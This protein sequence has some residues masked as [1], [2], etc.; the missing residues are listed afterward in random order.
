LFVKGYMPMMRRFA[1]LASSTFYI[2]FTAGCGSGGS[3]PVSSGSAGFTVSSLTFASTIV[4]T[5]AGAQALIFTNFTAVSI[6]IASVQIS[7]NSANDFSE[8]NTCGITLAAGASCTILV[9]F[10]PTAAGTCIGTVSVV[11]SA[12]NSPQVVTLSGTGAAVAPLA[13]L[14]PHNGLTYGTT[15]IAS[16]ATTQTA[17][18]TNTGTAALTISGIAFIG[19]NPGDF[20][21]TNT[22][23]SSVAVS[24]SCTI[25]V[26][27]TPTAAGARSA[28]LTVTDNSST[29]SQSI[30]VA[31]TGAATAVPVASLSPTSLTFASG[32]AQVVT[33]SNTGASAMTISGITITGANPTNFTETNTCGSSLASSTSCTISVTFSPTGSGSYAATLNV[34]DNAAGSPQAASLAGTATPVALLSPTNLTFTAAISGTTTVAQTVTVT[35]TGTASMTGV[36]VSLTG[37]SAA[38]FAQTNTCSST[39]AVNASCTISVTFT[40][41]ASGT[42]NA[43]ISVTDN[44]SGSPQTVSLSGLDT[45]S[46][47]THTLYVFPQSDNSVTPLYALINNAK[48]TIDMAMYSLEDTIFSGDLVAACNRGVTVRVILD[49]TTAE[50]SG[51]TPAFK[52]LNAV[53]HCSAVWANTAFEN[54]HQKTIIVDGTQASI[55]SLNLQSQYYSTSRDY[56]L[57]ENDT[58]D[59]AAIEATFNAD[60]AA[61]TTSSGTVGAS[62]F[63][64]QPGAGDDLIW[65]PTT[66]EADMLAIINNATATLLVENE[67][68]DVSYIVNALEAA[69]KRGV[70][71]HIAMEDNSNYSSYFAELVAAGCGLHT[72]PYPTNGF[73][74]HA[75]AVVA[76]YGLNTQNIYMGSINYSNASMTK[77]RELGLYISDAT[78]AQILYATMTNDYANGANY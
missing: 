66:A 7:G 56:V 64:Y 19:T 20:S 74:I 33:L 30:V 3:A 62:D 65:S 34:A 17:T 57:V 72:Y 58:A 54:F 22:C 13:D 47:V 29:A 9:S 78:S 38:S 44:A 75:K 2:A 8:T 77:N 11:D 16:T 55:M 39:L 32:A 42:V 49:Q 28:S 48:Q 41:T 10:T 4:G 21:Q 69:S 40:P 24:T 37:T 36:A 70:I 12:A 23:G 60:Y 53:T 14:E 18:L 26:S 68:M 61:G 67:E 59:I 71:V 25:T 50:K 52:Q 27:F 51:N 35:N 76:D 31:G 6:T 1:L 15:V 43:R 46:A 45:T 73:Y 5:S 63:S